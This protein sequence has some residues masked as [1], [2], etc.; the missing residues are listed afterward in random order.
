MTEENAPR[1]NAAAVSKFIERFAAAL[2][3]SGVPRM[4]A[5][6]FA[7]LLASDAG[8]LTAAELADTL[9]ISPAAVSGAVRYLTHVAMAGRERVPGSRRDHIVVR[10]D[11]W[12]EVLMDRDRILKQWADSLREGVEAL[13]ADTR[14]GARVAETLA[15]IEFMHAQLPILL[16]NWRKHREA[17]R[18]PPPSPPS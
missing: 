7:A 13:G 2:V 3:D 14:G 15:F 1:P 9:Q 12:Y 11:A 10:D 16:G 17:R 5:R 18:P 6:V 8:R 4:P